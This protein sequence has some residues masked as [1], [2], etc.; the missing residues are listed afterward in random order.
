MFSEDADAA[1]SVSTRIHDLFTGSA[2]TPGVRSTHGPRL[3]P[4]QR[5]GLS[6]P[7]EWWPA[8]PLLKEIEA[9]G[10]CWV[11]VP[12]PPADPSCPTRGWTRALPRPARVA[13]HRQPEPD[14]PRPGGLR[15]GTRRGPSRLGGPA[16]LRLRGGRRASSSTTPPTSPTPPRARTAL[17][18]ETRSLAALAPLAERLG[19]TLRAREPGAGLPRP[20]SRSPSRRWCCGRSCNRISSPNVGV[21]LDIGHANIVASLRHADPI[22][23][24][25][26]VLDRT[27]LFHLHD[28]L[29][30][31]RRQR[32]PARARSAPPRPPSPTRARN[33]S[34]GAD[35]A[36]PG[37][38]RRAAAARGA[39]T[40]TGASEDLRGGHPPAGAR[41]ARPGLDRIRSGAPLP[42]PQAWVGSTW[43]A[44]RCSD[45]EGSSSDSAPAA[46]TKATDAQRQAA[47]PYHW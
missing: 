36:A 20:A 46:S 7:Y 40:A 1:A 9:A 41:R 24:I 39:P 26:P 5:L 25:E 12:A 23:L 35:R 42:S 47:S 33:R 21:C 32:P 37:P 6:V 27:V 11:Q 43:P 4:R 19:V 22:E 34:L 8:A 28:N 31:R 14:R 3:R 2:R 17:L 10:F 38:Q 18:A 15:A 16:R 29:G 45:L 13:R 44:G 30:A